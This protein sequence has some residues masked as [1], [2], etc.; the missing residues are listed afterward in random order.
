MI[1][2]EIP[3]RELADLVDLGERSRA[4]EWSLRA[5]LVRYAQPEARR[6]EQILDQVR[7]IE[8]VCHEHHSTLVKRSE[9]VWAA[10][11]GAEPGAVDPLLVEVLR[12]AQVL[13]ALGDVL[14]AWAV[15]RAGERPNAEV[16]RV[17]ADVAVRLDAL[18]V[19]VQEM[20]PE[21]RAA[22]RRGRA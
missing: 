19:P 4:D 5:A 1:A 10:L 12:I 2:A 7:R 22:M 6:V 3:L 9:E 18:G 20:P 13:D 11:A 8:A 16:D 17:V 15:D 21:V 14:A